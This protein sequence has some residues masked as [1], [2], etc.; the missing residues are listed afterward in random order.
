MILA[1]KRGRRSQTRFVS[2][3]NLAAARKEYEKGPAWGV[4]RAFFYRSLCPYLMA[5]RSTPLVSRTK[6]MPMTKV[7][8]A[9]AIGYHSP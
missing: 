3:S 7:I 8:A 6:M 5:S 9:I 2:K 4:G 1:G